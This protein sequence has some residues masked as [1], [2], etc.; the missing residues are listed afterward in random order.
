[1]VHYHING[2]KLLAN[3][4]LAINNATESPFLLSN[5]GLGSEITFRRSFGERW[6][7]IATRMATDRHNGTEMSAKSTSIK[8][9]RHN[10]NVTSQFVVCKLKLFYQN[11]LYVVAI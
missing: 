6:S 3:M 10:I 8:P 1:M 9:I 5:P 4:I 7:P 2:Y 11:C